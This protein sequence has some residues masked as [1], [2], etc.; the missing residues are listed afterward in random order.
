M[1]MNKIFFIIGNILLS[2]TLS[3]AH[4]PQINNCRSA[5]LKFGDD[6]NVWP[7]FL[8][9]HCEEQ[10][11]AYTVSDPMDRN[12]MWQGLYESYGRT[13][14][15]TRYEMTLP[16][17]TTF[18]L[19]RGNIDR[20]CHWL[21][22]RA[23]TVLFAARC[24]RGESTHPPQSGWFDTESGTNK[25]YM[26]V[27]LYRLEKF[28]MMT[29]RLDLAGYEHREEMS[30]SS[31]LSSDFSVPDAEDE[32]DTKL[33]RRMMHPAVSRALGE[34]LRRRYTSE[35]DRP[36]DAISIDGLF[37]A[38][39]LERALGFRQ[40]ALSCLT[41]LL[42]ELNLIWQVPLSQWVGPESAAYCC[43]DKYRLSFQHWRSSRW[44]KAL[45]SLG[46]NSQFISFLEGLSGKLA[47]SVL[48]HSVCESSFSATG[49]SGLVPMR[50]QEE[51][52]QWAGSNVIG[53]ARGGFLYV[54][55]DVSTRH[56]DRL[57]DALTC[58]WGRDFDSSTC[59]RVYIGELTCCST[60]TE[61]GR[62]NG[63]ELILSSMMQTF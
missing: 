18:K 8:D 14:D 53:V 51:R 31:L 26:D 59:G 37:N 46:S 57:Y 24:Q 13:A 29:R 15:S 39:L 44:A 2:M 62:S 3:M 38:S 22:A 56:R 12:R 17:G 16:N 1:G 4:K 54:H 10:P 33:L 48:I 35:D 58:L 41:S 25:E 20:K 47:G 55:N 40:V 36:V 27:R 45:Q 63:R 7:L 28:P 23:S 6:S 11:D 43:K 5:K 52:L 19:M 21:I 34:T 32:K 9:K 61:T 50:V 42:D 30:A 49:I 60:S